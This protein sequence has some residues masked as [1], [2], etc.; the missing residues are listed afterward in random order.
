M[1]NG[2]L[3]SN[4]RAK[5]ILL[6]AQQQTTVSTTN[7]TAAYPALAPLDSKCALYNVTPQLTAAAA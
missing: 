6:A 7:G 1:A 4:R 5:H 3:L 2:Q